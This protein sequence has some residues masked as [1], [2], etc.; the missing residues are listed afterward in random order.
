MKWTIVSAILMLL[1][2]VFACTHKIEGDIH[3]EIPE[4]SDVLSDELEIRQ[5]KTIE[6]VHFA[7]NGDIHMFGHTVDAYNKKQNRML[8][9]YTKNYQLI[10]SIFIT[11]NVHQR[12]FIDAS[13]NIYIVNMQNRYSKLSYPDYKSV[14]IP[15]HP[16]HSGIL[17][18]LEKE[19]QQYKNG[20]NAELYKELKQADKLD[21]IEKMNDEV[22]DELEDYYSD[23]IN[24]KEIKFCYRFQGNYILF[25]KNGASFTL[26]S[27]QLRNGKG[28]LRK[29]LQN[30]GQMRIYSGYNTDDWSSSIANLDL[31][32]AEYITE[33]DFAVT[34]SVSTLENWPNLGYTMGYYYYKLELDDFN[35]DFKVKGSI[36]KTILHEVS[37]KRQDVFFIKTPKWYLIRRL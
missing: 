21:E 4:L 10:D 35:Y 20:P 6:T 23:N 36:N 18:I 2:G 19:I 3:P 9:R 8:W 16:S 25:M 34:E 7:K 30:N 17:K 1:C 14:L 27:S 24:L 13:S 37:K 22:A 28:A 26:P 11:D 32:D 5:L 31:K 33:T 15:F 12:W 29:Y